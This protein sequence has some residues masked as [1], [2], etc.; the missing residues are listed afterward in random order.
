MELQTPID[1][2]YHNPKTNIHLLESNMS[3]KEKYLHR[4]GEQ[5]MQS[6]ISLSYTDYLRCPLQ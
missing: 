2:K 5:I 1:T 6:I 3:Q 4:S